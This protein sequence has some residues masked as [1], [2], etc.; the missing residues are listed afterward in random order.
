MYITYHIISHTHIKDVLHTA[1]THKRCVT[2]TYTHTPCDLRES[3]VESSLEN[4]IKIIVPVFKQTK[5][6]MSPP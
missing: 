4:F 6:I 1:Q 2:H 5:N 3:S